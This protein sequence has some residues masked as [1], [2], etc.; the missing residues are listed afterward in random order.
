MCVRTYKSAIK[1]FTLSCRCQ[2]KM[3]TSSWYLI[4]SYS[5][6]KRFERGV[7]A[8]VLP[9][10]PFS[11]AAKLST[12]SS[13]LFIVSSITLILDL[14]RDLLLLGYSLKLDEEEDEGEDDD[15]GHEVD[16]LKPFLKCTQT[17]SPAAASCSCC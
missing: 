16:D 2:G 12:V 7:R 15:E 14:P 11:P 4:F 10:A 5:S 6:F 17:P 13:T 3:L 1:R 9:F 8:L